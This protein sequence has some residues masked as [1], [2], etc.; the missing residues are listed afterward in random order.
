[1]QAVNNEQLILMFTHNSYL[2]S[3]NETQLLRFCLLNGHNMYE[4]VV[5][6]FSS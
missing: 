5:C 4:F 3:L 1:M 2:K 6:K